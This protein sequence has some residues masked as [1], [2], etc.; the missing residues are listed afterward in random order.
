MKLRVK[1]RA[2]A[3]LK[4]SQHAMAVKQSRFWLRSVLWSLMAASG[5]SIA[6]LVASVRTNRRNCHR[7]G[8]A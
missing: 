3:V 5:F 4:S 1:E 2:Q 8:K 6:W 7:P